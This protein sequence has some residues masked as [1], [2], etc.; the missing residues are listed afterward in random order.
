M[1]P[2]AGAAVRAERQ[3]TLE[4]VARERFVDDRIGG[5][6]DELRELE[7]E[8]PYDSDDASLIRVTRRDWEKARC[9][10][11]GLAAELAKAASEGME[12][13]VAAREAERLRRLPALARPA[14]RVEAGVHLVLRGDR[15]PVRHPARRLRAGDDDGRGAKRL[16]P[17][18]GRV[19]AV[20]RGRRQQALRQRARRRA[21]PRRRAARRSRWLR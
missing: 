9:V 14:S 12:A 15:R 1:M 6:V 21:V 2:S 19:R 4:R 8:L 11:V 18:P 3:A 16:R 17:A 13:W 7:A 10:P 20:D 5:L